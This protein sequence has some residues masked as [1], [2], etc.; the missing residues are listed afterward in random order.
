M[1]IPM[2]PTIIDGGWRTG[3]LSFTD[4]TPSCAGEG[5]VNVRMRELREARDRKDPIMIMDV[6]G[7]C[8]KRMGPEIIRRTKKRKMNIWLMTSITSV[9]DIFDAFYSGSSSLFMPLHLIPSENVLKEINTLSEECVPTLF[10]SNGK[11]LGSRDAAAAVALARRCGYRRICVMETS[12]TYD[13]NLWRW[14]FS[15]GMDVIP[16]VH[17]INEEGMKDLSD[18]GFQDILI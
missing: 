12:G 17:K 14:L 8:D 13:G 3:S 15:T 7:I 16:Y 2:I 6:D 5:D 11:A 4:G 1:I 10:L 18:I 9:D